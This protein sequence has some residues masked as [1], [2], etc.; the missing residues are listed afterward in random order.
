MLPTTMTQPNPPHISN[1]VAAQSVNATQAFTLN[2]DVFV[3]GTT[4]DYV[5]VVV[6]ANNTWQTPSPG[7]PGALNGTATSVTI[8]PTH[9]SRIPTTQQPSGFI[10]SL[11]TPTPPTRPSPFGPTPLS[12]A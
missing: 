10:V 11:V 2:W 12:S 3:G 4:T 7:A 8:R 1:F 5:Y 9:S 6:G